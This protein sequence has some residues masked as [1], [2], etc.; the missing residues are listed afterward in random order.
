MGSSSERQSEGLVRPT[1]GISPWGGSSRGKKFGLHGR[2][3]HPA[4]MMDG[5]EPTNDT[6]DLPEDETLTDEL[7]DLFEQMLD[8]FFP[9]E[10][11]DEPEGA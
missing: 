1:L 10:V 11:E 4:L 7:L 5:M 2:L 3:A 6:D 9:S 8:E